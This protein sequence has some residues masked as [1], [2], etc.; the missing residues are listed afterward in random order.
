[1]PLFREGDNIILVD[2]KNREYYFKLASGKLIDLRGGKIS[3]DEII[4]RQEGSKIT[5]SVGE[6]FFVLRPTLSQFILNMPRKGQIIYPKDIGIIL[7]WADVFPGAKVIEGGIGFG[8]LTMALLR[9]VGP[10]G[11]VI[12][13]EVR[14]DFAGQAKENIENFMGKV[15]NLKIKLGDIYQGIEEREVDRIIVDV[16]EPWRVVPHAAKA[17]KKGGIFL[18]YLP[19][20]IQ[21]RK[22]V[23]EIRSSREFTEVQIIEVLLRPWNVDGMSVR[24]AHRMV[25]HTGF[26][27]VARKI[28]FIS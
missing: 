16:P 3:H 4:G 20:I 12:S 11:K 22:V 6:T 19:T 2:R 24:P 26:I 5:S 13:Y 17:L 23:E 1:M 10:Q 18:S 27:T 8:A 28:K 7:I 14:G 25:A 9:A 21:V 15:D